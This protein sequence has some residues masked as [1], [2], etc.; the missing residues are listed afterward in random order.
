MGAIQTS[1]QIHDGMT[2]ALRN[3]TTALNICLSSFEAVQAAS[4][5]VIDT[6]SIDAAREALNETELTIHDIEENIKRAAKQQDTLNHSFRE[7]QQAADDLIGEMGG[8]AAVYAGMKMASALTEMSD[9]ITQTTARLDMMNDGLQTTEELQ[10]MIFQSAQ[11]SR[12]DYNATADAVA[13]L[14][15]NAGEAFASTQEIVRFSELVNKQFTIAGASSQEASNA[16]LQLTQ[17]MG[18]GVL[19]GDE[20]NSIFEQAPNLIQTIASYIEQNDVLLESM[21]KELKIKTEDLSGNVM[22]HIRDIASEGMISADIVKNAMFTAGEEI[23][24]KFAGM[25][26]TWGQ[27]ITGFRNEAIVQLQPLLGRINELANDQ[28]FQSILEG[29]VNLLGYAAEAGVVLIDILVKGI[30]TIE[31]FLPYL[32]TISAIIGA[33]VLAT[34]LWA[35]AQLLLNL[36]LSPLMI[37]AL[38]IAGIVG[39]IYLAVYAFN[40]LTGSSMSATGIIMGTFATLAA[41]IIN[42]VI[43]PAWNWFASLANFIANLFID[44]VA[45]IE[46]LFDDMAQ[47]ILGRIISI[48]E[49]I[50]FVINKIPGVEIDIT[51]GLNNLYDSIEAHSQKVKNESEWVEVVEKMDYIDYNEAWDAGYG[52]GEGIAENFPGFITT[53]LS[54]TSEEETTGAYDLNINNNLDS[55][56]DSTSDI[57]DSLAITEEDL[58]Y[59]LELGEREAINRFT[60][61]E[62]KVDLGGVVNQV[63]SNTDL[64]GMI[65]Y[66][67]GSLEEQMAVMADGVH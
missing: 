58:K 6:A 2:V 50:E 23:D 46:I 57:S 40:R 10:Q 30:E 53:E 14:G 42:Q 63:S 7:G 60:T 13:K 19:R 9:N 35:A 37:T 12:A 64:D 55:I 38:I 56:A 11:N 65:D 67:A 34:K 1:I 29:A 22:G 47:F 24:E 33:I 20:L 52:F 8:L 32:I 43:V 45:A 3:M 49:M 44:P 4:S 31:P 18:S 28:E 54:G 36:T 41:F 21:A 5:N 61:A 59:L 17:A 26:V 39:A 66:L 48:A 16:F 51:S 25:P 62:I 27:A 15:N